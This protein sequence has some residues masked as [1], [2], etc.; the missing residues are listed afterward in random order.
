MISLL[1]LTNNNLKNKVMIS[2]KIKVCDASRE[3]VK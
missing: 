3:K 2:K 1:D